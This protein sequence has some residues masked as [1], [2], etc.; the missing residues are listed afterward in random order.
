MVRLPGPDGLPAAG[1]REALNP[2]HSL[3]DDLKFDMTQQGCDGVDDYERGYE[4]GHRMAVIRMAMH[5][6]QEVGADPNCPEAVKQM[7]ALL[8]G[9]RTKSREYDGIIAYAQHQGWDRLRGTLYSWLTGKLHGQVHKHEP[10]PLTVNVQFRGDPEK[11]RAVVGK[12]LRWQLY[13]KATVEAVMNLGYRS[14]AASRIATAV[15]DAIELEG[16]NPDPQPPQFDKDREAAVNRITERIAA[17]EKRV[18]NGALN[19][20]ERQ[21]TEQRIAHCEQLLASYLA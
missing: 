5:F 11:A 2:H 8:D 17:F 15:E 10:E 14:D 3:M 13:R 7:L 21:D 9:L 20:T 16:F 4:A 6:L 12:Q 19:T 18:A 1:L